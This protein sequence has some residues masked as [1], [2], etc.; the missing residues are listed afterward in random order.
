M[1]QPLGYVHPNYPDYVCRLRKALYGLKQ[2]PRAW[3]DRIADYLMDF[4]GHM[5]IIHS[6]YMKM[7]QGLWPLLYMWMILLLWE[8]M[9]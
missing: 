1:E 4:I 3:H 9:P 6:M 5:L 8:T 7:T 2:A